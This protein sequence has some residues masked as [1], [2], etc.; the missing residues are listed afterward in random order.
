MDKNWIGYSLKWSAPLLKKYKWKF[1]FVMVLMLVSVVFTLIHVNFIQRSIDAVLIRDI[2][3]LMRILFLFAAVAVFR[4]I[5]TYVYRRSYENLFINMEKDLKNKFTDKI[6]KTKMKEIDREN[7]GDLNTK[8]N[9]D[10][11]TLPEKKSNKR[12]NR[13][14]CRIISTHSP[15]DCIQFYPKT[16]AI[17]PAASVSGFRLRG[18]FSEIRRSVYSTNR[19]LRSTRAQNRQ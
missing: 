14:D 3:G 6:L 11:R 12:Q 18:H 1:L 4:L 7:S 10:A 13:R 19:P 2:G 8:C 17:C 5:H 16:A 9:S 15:M